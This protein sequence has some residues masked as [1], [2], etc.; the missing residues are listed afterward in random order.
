MNKQ[1]SKNNLNKIG[2]ILAL[3]SAFFSAL[4]VIFE[5]KYILL[6][7]SESILF[8]MYLGAGLGLLITYLLT[9]NSSKIKQEKITK[10]ELPQVALIVICELVA[11]LLIIE[12]LKIVSAGVVSLL[13]VFE[14]IMTSIFAYLIFKEPIENNELVSIVLIIIGFVILN[15]DINSI[16]Q[17]SISSLLVIGACISWGLENNVTSL[18][19]SKEPALFTSVK[20]L[21]VSILYLVI[22]LIGNSLD[23]SHPILLFYGFLS[24]GIG[25]LTYALSTKYLGANKA[26]LIFSFNPIFGVLLAITLYKEVVTTSFFISSIIMIIAIIILNKPSKKKS[27]K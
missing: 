17:I 7:N 2:V 13:L 22:A 12:A 1:G 10:K 19:S 20:C 4:Y 23:I 8:L 25:I 9:K 24:Y 3:I 27:T 26:T 11:S 14:I 18:L 15:L 6:T 5:K 16:S 21:S